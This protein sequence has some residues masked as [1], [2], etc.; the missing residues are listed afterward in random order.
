MHTVL[1]PLGVSSIA[2]NKYINI[3]INKILQINSFHTPLMMIPKVGQTCRG[4]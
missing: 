1:L 3:I 4:P 2:V